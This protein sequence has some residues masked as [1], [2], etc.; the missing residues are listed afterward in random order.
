MGDAAGR[1]IAVVAQASI[2]AGRRPGVIVSHGLSL[3]THLGQRL[4]DRFDREPFGSGLTF[5]DAWASTTRARSTGR[6]RRRRPVRLAAQGWRWTWRAPAWSRGS[7]TIWSMFTWLGRVAA[8]AMQSATSSAVS[9][10]MP[11]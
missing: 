9:G 1:V 6:G 3:A 11:S 10:V 8:H 5:P 7:T 2:P 4:G